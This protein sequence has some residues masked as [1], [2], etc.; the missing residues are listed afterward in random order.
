MASIVTAASG[1]AAAAVPPV[2]EPPV[3]QH[4]G[5]LKTKQNR[6]VKNITLG[7]RVLILGNSD[8]KQ[9]FEAKL[10]WLFAREPRQTIYQMKLHASNNLVL[11]S[12]FRYFVRYIR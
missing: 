6:L 8:S 11:T 1:F 4:E 2:V 3:A 7:F 9:Y 12:P 5:A 10:T